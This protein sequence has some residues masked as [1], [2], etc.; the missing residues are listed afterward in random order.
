MP[1]IDFYILSTTGKQER[2]QFVCKLAEKIFRQKQK[3]FFLT[4]SIEVSEILDNL[5]WT[6]RPGSFIPHQI[7]QKN[8]SSFYDQLLISNQGLPEDW[9]GTLV[10]LTHQLVPNIEKLSRII[11]I[12]DDNEACRE[13]G[14]QRY[15]HYKK[16]N[17]I[18]NTHKM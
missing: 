8:S 7:L 15:R 16:M 3:A 1:T 4:P 12:I 2:Y 14:R 9:Y 17:L 10:N 5:L 13:E 18:P 11:E 6:F